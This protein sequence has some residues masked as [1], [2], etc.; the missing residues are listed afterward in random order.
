MTSCGERPKNCLFVLSFTVFCLQWRD[1]FVNDL[2]LS[3]ALSRC[4]HASRPEVGGG[5]GGGVTSTIIPP[6]LIRSMH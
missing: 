1:K 3:V 5:G 2:M 6:S 4:W